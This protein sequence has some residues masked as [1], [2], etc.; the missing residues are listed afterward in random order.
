MCSTFR[1]EFTSRYQPE[2][3]HPSERSATGLRFF[4]PVPGSRGIA[5]VEGQSLAERIAASGRI[6]VDEA[7]EI[8][9]RIT[10]ALEAAHTLC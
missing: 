9:R 1:I 2:H 3:D 4:A 7:L 6:A 5:L 10:L 8:A